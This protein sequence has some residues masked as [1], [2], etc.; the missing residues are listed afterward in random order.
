MRVLASF[1]VPSGHREP[2]ALGLALRA[3]EARGEVSV[4]GPS[5]RP[6][7]AQL[8]AASKWPDG[9]TRWLL[10]ELVADA[11]GGR[12][13]VVPGRWRPEGASVSVSLRDWPSG[14]PRDARLVASFADA[15]VVEFSTPAVNVESGGPVR[16]TVRAEGTLG[17]LNVRLRATVWAGFEAAR[18]EI[19]VH[20]PRGTK[21]DGGLWDL[22]DPGSVLLRDLSLVLPAPEQIEARVE[23]DAS[24]EP[25]A[26]IPWLL[27]QASS[28]GEHWN[29]HN[30]QNAN[31]VVPLRF[32]GWR[33]GERT[34]L[35]AQPELR[36]PGFSVALTEFWQNFP[37][38]I[39]VQPFE[40]RI[41]LLPAEHG[42]LHEL[43]GGERK[44][45]VVWV[46][47]GAPLEHVHAPRR[48]VQPP[49]EV[50]AAGVLGDVGPVE[51]DAP[52]VAARLARIVDEGTGL[53]ARREAIDEFGWRNWGDLW[54]DH[55]A[56]RHT[57]PTPFVSH[58]NNQYD[59]VYA[60]L[61]CQL[62]S[63]DVRFWHLADTLARHV[64]DVDL[65]HTEE[66]RALFNGGLFWHTD[67]YVDAGTSTHR[68]YSRKNGR[69]RTY[70]GGL[71]NE[72]NYTSGLLLYHWL[73]GDPFAA[74]AVLSLA[75]WVEAMDDGARSVFGLLAQ[76]PTGAASQTYTPDYH[77]P[78]RGAGNSINACCDAFDLTGEARWLSL[79]ERLVQRCVHPERDPGSDDLL[80][81]E[82]RWS[83]TV[84][85]KALLRYLH[86]KEG[87]AA[88]DATYAWARA[89]LV[90]HARWMVA[91]EQPSTT[92]KE[93]LEYLTETWPAQDLRKA[94]VAHGAAAYL[95][96]EEAARMH[97]WASRTFEAALEELTGYATH[98]RCR[99]LVLTIQ[100]A[101]AEAYA[102]AHP[103]ARAPEAP[104]PPTQ[105]PPFVPFVPQKTL[106]KRSLATPGGAAQA[107]L[108]L[109]RPASWRRLREPW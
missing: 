73:T 99:P 90:N 105:W 63:G 107:L 39:E 85:M 9:S 3:G 33:A 20:N 43:Q 101:L 67:H 82:A 25:V 46:G 77:G 37:R 38:A 84:F 65:Y 34:G 91:H 57:G 94:Q 44:R 88:F 17:P 97:A 42:D 48:A 55:E 89:C 7:A 29:C 50:L 80:D 104:D 93:R 24:F 6:C 16:A 83:Y 19:L 49:D 35:R 36:G 59:C 81:A 66:D 108:V 86:L 72:Q 14:L 32:R 103:D 41:G 22:G 47:R 15:R 87:L 8:T 70:G 75:R 53:A 95:P 40:V 58:Y 5:G 27:F 106:A 2:I 10:V 78:G 4:F 18:L 11:E 54:A 28:G 102:R 23:R 92:R 68:C 98:D 12:Y 61:L 13:T 76:G 71:S 69:S 52:D 21:H 100:P 45:H 96:P 62:R 74:E 56:V 79:A 64:M 26:P 109:G 51:L 31:G 1:D 60:F 30:H